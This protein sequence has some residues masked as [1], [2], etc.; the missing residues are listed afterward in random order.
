MMSHDVAG[1]P[2]PLLLICFLSQE[3]HEMR[4]QILC[5]IVFLYSYTLF[6][7]DISGGGVL[8]GSTQPCAVKKLTVRITRILYTLYGDTSEPPVTKVVINYF[9]P[10]SKTAKSLG[11]T[12][13]NSNGRTMNPIWNSTDGTLESDDDAGLM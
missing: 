13:E 7:R 8:K 9:D 1:L 6:V 11:V 4:L 10:K 12:N 5:L 2:H 3:R